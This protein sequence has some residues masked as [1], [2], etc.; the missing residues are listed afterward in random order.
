MSARHDVEQFL[1]ELD[2]KYELLVAALEDLQQS[3][4]I[5]SY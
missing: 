2:H 5:I 3:E 4:W 1:D